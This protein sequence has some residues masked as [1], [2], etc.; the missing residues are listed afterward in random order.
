MREE[1]SR[2]EPNRFLFSTVPWFVYHTTRKFQTF[3]SPV[4]HTE[5]G[6][7]KPLLAL[8]VPMVGLQHHQ[9]VSSLD[10]W[11]TMVSLQH[12]LKS[13]NPFSAL[14]FAMVSPKSTQTIQ[15]FLCSVVHYG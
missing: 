2:V 11:I 13:L 7:T 10:L 6:Q 9:K 12:K 3:L 4:V 8:R 15:A 5:Q 1:S 14:W